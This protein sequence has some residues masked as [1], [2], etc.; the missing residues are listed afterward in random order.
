M[1]LLLRK[2]D[3]KKKTFN[4]GLSLLFLNVS[5]YMETVT[6]SKAEFTFGK[7]GSEAFFL[8]YNHRNNPLFLLQDIIVNNQLKAQL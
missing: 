6:K 5:L 8:L 1:N 3:G 2:G 4:F 7:I